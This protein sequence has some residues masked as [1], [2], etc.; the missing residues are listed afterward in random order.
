ML[1]KFAIHKAMLL[2][3][4]M[5]L[6]GAYCME[7]NPK[8]QSEGLDLLTAVYRTAIICMHHHC[9]Q[10]MDEGIR[11]TD[12]QTKMNAFRRTLNFLSEQSKNYTLNCNDTSMKQHDK[13]YFIQMLY[14]STKDLYSNWARHIKLTSPQAANGLRNLCLGLVD[15]DQI[16]FQH[17]NLLEPGLLPSI[18]IPLATSNFLT[19]IANLFTNFHQE[20]REEKREKE[21]YAS[22]M[23]YYSALKD[24]TEYRTIIDKNM[25]VI[26]QRMSEYEMSSK[27]RSGLG[28]RAQLQQKHAAFSSRQ[29]IAEHIM[30]QNEAIGLFDAKAVFTSIIDLK[31]IASIE[32]DKNHNLTSYLGK[33]GDTYR[34]LCFLEDEVAKQLKMNK[35]ATGWTNAD[36][37]AIYSTISEEVTPPVIKYR[38]EEFLIICLSMEDYSGAN[39]RLHAFVELLGGSPS[40]FE[41]VPNDLK[42]PYAAVKYFLGE[43][44]VWEKYINKEITEQDK[45][46]EER[47]RQKEK[48]RIAALKESMAKVAADAHAAEEQAKAAKESGPTSKAHTSAQ[49]TTPA[50]AAASSSSSSSA[51]QNYSYYDPTTSE[52]KKAAQLQIEAEERRQALKAEKK[53]KAE[54]INNNNQPEHAKYEKN[55]QSQSNQAPGP[56]VAPSIFAVSKPTLDLYNN[57]YGLTPKLTTENAVQLLAGFGLTIHKNEGKGSHTKC[58]LNNGEKIINAAGK[59]MWTCPDFEKGGLMAIVPRWDGKDIPLYMIKHLRYIIE[60][61]GVQFG[62]TQVMT[63]QEQLLKP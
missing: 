11:S 3:C 18:D 32:W 31:N 23:I 12:Q 2:L 25:A 52:A 51:Y 57:L 43:P 59:V 7:E 20:V 46:R 53:E 63:T 47:K 41:T 15:M 58:F 19:H 60:K 45:K 49:V 37:K 6:S 29:Q 4:S 36:F 16:V 17:F 48:K 54:N 27:P 26:K 13:A 21:L 30:K 22:A 56:E 33:Q 5:N 14:S 24:N 28:K 40:Q 10:M 35:P 38:Y 39:L 1:N 61:M 55:Q 34:K 8:P 42:F 50:A 44:E 62:T 9:Q